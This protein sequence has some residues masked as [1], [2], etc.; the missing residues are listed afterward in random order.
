[1]KHR[2]L[3]ASVPDPCRANALPPEGKQNPARPANPKSPKETIAN[4]KGP[5]P[6]RASSPITRASVADA[7]MPQPAPRTVGPAR[8]C[9]ASQNIRWLRS[10]FSQTSHHP[11]RPP[12]NSPTAA[13]SPRTTTRRRDELNATSSPSAP[14]RPYPLLRQADRIILM[15]RG[16][17]HEDRISR[18]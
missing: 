17:L 13:P 5:P 9:V 15:S 14:R 3:G 2:T 18:L 7:R 11:R 12:T 6:R 1:P 16:H 8:R 4:Q 10:E